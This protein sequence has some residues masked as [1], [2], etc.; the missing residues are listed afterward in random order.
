[1]KRYLQ[2]IPVCGKKPAIPNYTESEK[3]VMVGFQKITLFIDM[4]SLADSRNSSQISSLSNARLES[5]TL[6]LRLAIA[7]IRRKF[8]IKFLASR[9]MKQTGLSRLMRVDSSW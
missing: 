8:L 2:P 4:P 5:L 6:V 7:S 1:M 3:V 9:M